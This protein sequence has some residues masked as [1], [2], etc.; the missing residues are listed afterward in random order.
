MEKIRWWHHKK[1][2]FIDVLDTEDLMQ[3]MQRK[4]RTRKVFFLGTISDVV[5]QVI[6]DVDARVVA[7]QNEVV[8]VDEI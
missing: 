3:I 1:Q 2:E 4:K 7:G 8:D 6:V 5:E